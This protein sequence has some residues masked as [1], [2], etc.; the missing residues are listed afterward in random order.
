MWLDSIEIS[1]WRSF[2]AGGSPLKLSR[3][4]RVNLLVGPNNSGKSN[5]SR[6]FH[7]LAHGFHNSLASSPNQYQWNNP[8]P[9]DY[10]IS[11]DDFNWHSPD[12]GVSARLTYS[13]PE[14]I[15]DLHPINEISANQTVTIDI[16][17]H[18]HISDTTNILYPNR[19]PV[20]SPEQ[21]DSQNP[22]FQ[23]AT[24]SGEIEFIDDPVLAS[25]LRNSLTS[26]LHHCFV[27]SIRIVGPHR[28]PASSVGDLNIHISPS[29]VAG[30]VFGLRGRSLSESNI[31]ETKLNHWLS[32][33]VGQGPMY[34]GFLPDG[35][36]PT[37][38]IKDS[39]HIPPAPLN[40]LG[41]GIGEAFT[42]LSFLHLRAREHRMILFIDELEAFLHPSS[43]R[44]LIKIISSNF[45][46]VQFFISTHSTALLDSIE[47]DWRIF[48]FTQP[49]HGWSHVEA[50]ETPGQQ[51]EV[52]QSLGFRPSQLFIANSVLWV[53]GPSDA[54]YLLRLITQVDPDLLEGRDFTFAFYGGSNIRHVSYE[55]DGENLVKLLHCSLA[56]IVICDRDRPEGDALKPAVERLKQEAKTL[57]RPLLLTPGYEIE[58]LLEPRALATATQP[59]IDR[60]HKE[61]RGTLTADHLVLSL[62]LN[63]ALAGAIEPAEP[64]KT[65][66]TEIAQRL[67]NKK[68]QLARDICALSDME[69]F[70]EDGLEFGKKLCKHI[71]SHH[72]R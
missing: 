57:D 20:I 38:K 14:N 21:Y 63:R 67:A 46:N 7:R 70:S 44:E 6:F 16:L 41:T 68:V 17:V 25:E 54:I 35:I 9:I 15:F 4:G 1:G 62:S 33:I 72:E 24:H 8:N 58:S 65:T 5:L 34:L 32:R 13:T 39:D 22:Y 11:K 23:I 36:T 53:E 28:D 71:R 42:I 61:N 60:M 19:K 49:V 52:I 12:H 43:A 50:V 47:P 40:K 31:L 37:L 10:G 64:N 66:S 69:I 2:P 3:L 29:T 59:H 48:K 26:L 18:P 56:P 45:E 30:E 51:L 55:D 27:G